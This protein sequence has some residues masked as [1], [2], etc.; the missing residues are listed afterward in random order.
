MSV[1]KYYIAALDNLKAKRKTELALYE[2]QRQRVFDENPRLKEIEFELAK[3][4][5][6]LAIAALSGSKAKIEE[7]R[8]QC[9]ALSLEKQ[10][11]LEAA[12]L[13]EPAYECPVCKD[14]GK[15]GGK[16]C[17][18]VKLRGRALMAEEL[19]SEMPLENST[20][21]N[22]SLKYY[23]DTADENGVAPKKRMTQIFKSCVEFAK[24]FGKQTKN[25][26]FL[27]EAGLGKTHLSLAIVNEVLAKGYEAVYS[28]AGTLFDRIEKEHFAYTG[29]EDF[30]DTVL[31]ADLLVIDDLGTEFSTQF[32][33]S[34]VYNII[35]TRILKNKATILSTNLTIEELRNRYNPRVCSRLIGHYEFK[36]FTGDDIRLKKALMK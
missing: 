17:E 1:N 19:G 13:A 34:V 27:G 28:P 29:S 30:L 8:Q 22:F 24:G 10:K 36:Q 14:E 3:S 15:V 18:C 33:Q 6:G 25:L 16:F 2:A 5:A 23:S 7:I 21:E 4:G 9:E 32:T 20:F 12:N 31:N 26:L 35:N 11:I